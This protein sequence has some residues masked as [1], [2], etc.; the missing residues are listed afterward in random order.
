M[1]LVGADAIADDWQAALDDAGLDAGDCRL[2][3]LDEPRPEPT[4]AHYP[5]G[6]ALAADELIDE[7]FAAELN[8]PK[9]VDRHRVVVVR[10]APAEYGRALVAAKMRH[11]LEHARQWNVLGDMAKVLGHLV[12]DVVVA[13][14]G[15]FNDEGRAIYHGSPSE[16]GADAAASAFVRA[17]FTSAAIEPIA[18]SKDAFLDSTEPSAEPLEAL[19]SRTI[20]FLSEYA[21]GC[22]TVPDF[23]DRLHEMAPHFLEL[24][25]SLARQGK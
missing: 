18:A 10:D 3:C 19:P 14:A 24:W 9:N 21:D 7:N 23:C 5:P 6:W 22:A 16:R 2:L 1:P 12:E 8:R 20:S 25:N 15:S 17:R 13:V 11:E 4:A